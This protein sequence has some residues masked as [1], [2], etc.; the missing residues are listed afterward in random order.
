GGAPGVEGRPAGERKGQ[1]PR[2]PFYPHSW[3]AG[4]AHHAHLARLR[5][6]RDESRWLH[7][8]P[9]RRHRVAH[10]PPE[11]PRPRAWLRRAEPTT[12][13]RG[14]HG[15]RQPPPHGPRHLTK[16]PGPRKL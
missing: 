15:Y 10:R 8:P 1:P 2:K 4:H 12:R 3:R 16:P 6:H 11:K 9:R 14:L 7:R 13:L 5:L